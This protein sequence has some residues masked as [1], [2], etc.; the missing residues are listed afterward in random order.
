M[1]IR[2][3]ADAEHAVWLFRLNYDR[4]RG[5]A[6]SDLIQEIASRADARPR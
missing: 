1:S 3:E 6:A 5:Q 4:L 2:T